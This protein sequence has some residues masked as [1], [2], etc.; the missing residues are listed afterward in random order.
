[1]LKQ[2]FLR[3]VIPTVVIFMFYSSAYSQ[4]VPYRVELL[5]EDGN[6]IVFN[7]T[8]SSVNGKQQWVIRNAGERIRV[9]SIVQKGDS[10]LVEMPLFDSRMRVHVSKDKAMTGTWTRAITSGMATMPVT[11][12][13][14]INYRFPPLKGKA[15]K[16]ISG[17][18]AV[19]FTRPDGTKRK[20]VAEFKQKDNNLTGTFLNPSGDYRFLEGIVTGDSVLLS[21]FDGAHAYFFGATIRSDGSLTNG[22]FHSLV[23]STERWTAKKDAAARLDEAGAKV[24]MKDGEE[25]L[26]FSFPDL[27]SNTVSINDPRFK[28][29][30]V[31][32]QLMGSWCPNCM[33]E[34]AFLS[35]YYK[36]NK[37]RGFEVVGL[38]YEY[39]T[40]FHKSEK[41]LR[42][43]QQRFKVEY[44][45]LITGVTTIDSLKTEKTLP[46]ITS[47]KGFPT[48][49]Y[50]GRDGTVKK[51]ASGF[52]GPGTGK[53]HEVF[54]KEFEATMDTMLKE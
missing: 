44:P 50:I 22:V 10:L 5:R 28:G 16:N 6:T 17:R 19:E 31:V 4:P 14:G 25:R 30:V 42:K 29:K 12:T 8:S 2:G 26:N 18:Y 54:K 49:I 27:D 7:F 11:A 24:Y 46:Q 15:L 51:I 39:T 40:D 48:T 20:S 52:N 36:K 1:M 37:A 3:Y 53:Y 47:I 32:V 34:T 38:A 21:C 9:D 41:P 35:D 45:M 33:D 23:R 13:P 43:F